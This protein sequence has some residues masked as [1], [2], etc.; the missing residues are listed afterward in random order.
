[1]PNSSRF[2]NNP[3]TRSCSRNDLEKQLVFR[4]QRFSRV[5]NVVVPFNLL[6]LYFA[7]GM[8]FWI[9]GA[10]VHVCTIGIEMV[11][12]QWGQQCFSQSEDFI[13]RAR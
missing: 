12:A 9:E 13:S 3:I 8:L 10:I 5:R 1:M 2:T 6:R 4:T 11:H 7:N